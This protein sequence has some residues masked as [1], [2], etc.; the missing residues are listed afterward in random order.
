MEPLHVILC[1]F[2]IYTVKKII[3]RYLLT[4]ISAVVYD[5][6]SPLIKIIFILCRR[7]QPFCL[8]RDGHRR[9]L[10]FSYDNL[11]IVTAHHS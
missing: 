6:L 8:D 9:I 1:L 3:V 7:Y 2:D 10:K 4:G 5:D 11:Y